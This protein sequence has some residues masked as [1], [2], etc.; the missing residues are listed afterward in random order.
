MRISSVVGAIIDDKKHTVRELL[1]KTRAA[2]TL[3]YAHL[4]PD[5]KAL[6]VEELCKGLVSMEELR[7]FQDTWT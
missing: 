1:G 2:T 3:R 6:A 4:A 5:H 7:Q